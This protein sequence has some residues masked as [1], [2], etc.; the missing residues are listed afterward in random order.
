MPRRR[1]ARVPV[2]IAVWSHAAPG[3]D[4]RRRHERQHQR[5]GHAAGDA[6]APRHRLQARPHLPLPGAI[7]RPCARWAR[8][9][10]RT[11]GDGGPRPARRRVPDPARRRARPHPRLRRSAAGEEL[12]VRASLRLHGEA[13]QPDPRP[14]VPLPVPAPHRGLR[15]PGVRPQGEGR[16]HPHHRRG[17]HGQDDA[18]PLLPL[19]PRRAHRHRRSSSTPRS[20]RPSC[21]ARSWRTCTCPPPATSLKDHVDALHRFLLEARGDGPRRRAP[22]RRGPGPRRRRCW[23]RSASSRTSRPTPRS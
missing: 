17:G 21:C 14:Q 7:R 10:A 18:R 13:V 2:S 6:R 20:P 22:H 3:S 16:L 23:S 19:P 9:C 4:P 1:E 15:P 11:D 8:S 5:E 12:D